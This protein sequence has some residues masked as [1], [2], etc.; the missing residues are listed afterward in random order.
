MLRRAASLLS[1][2]GGSARLSILI[3]HRVHASCDALF[4]AE[5]DVARFDAIC[6]WLKNWFNVLPLED[7]VDRLQGGRLPPRAA[8]ITF[9]DG[10]A[11]NHDVAL[12]ILLRHRLPC[13]F[14]IATGY[15]DG[16]RMFNDSIVELVR[17]CALPALAVEG[18]G[19][20]LSSH[21]P[22][23]LGDHRARVAAIR[24]LIGAL[25][26]RPP[27][28]R[29]ALCLALERRA[30]VS[31]LPDDLMMSREQVRALHRAGMQVGAHTVTHPILAHLDA[32]QARAEIEGGKSD[33][34]CIVGRPVSLFAYPNG[35]PGTDYTN[36]T[37]KL[38]REIGF[39]AAVSTAWGC[40]DSHTDILQL[41]R[42]TPWDTNSLR[43]GVRLLSNLRRRPALLSD[44]PT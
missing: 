18:L 43:F 3:F 14:F 26:Y 12:P 40:S 24:A 44:R 8:C 29:L 1:P 19:L 22:L 30:G 23:A 7:A 6:G 25:K 10:Y 42:F 5:P 39:R 35:Q 16:G 38:V 33:L 11:D 17:R 4:P 31:A 41:P 32:A 21:A 34:E 9:D 36:E 37:M 13:T 28:E 20:R 15:L 2:G 27:P